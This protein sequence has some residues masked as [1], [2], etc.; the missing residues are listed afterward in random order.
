[1]VPI[2]KRTLQS[3]LALSMTWFFSLECTVNPWSLIPVYSIATFVPVVKLKMLGD[4]HWESGA[5]FVLE[6]AIMSILSSQIS[7]KQIALECLEEMGVEDDHMNILCMGGRTVGP[8]V[9]WDLVE[10][11]L[12][13]SYSQEPRHLR[14]LGKVALLDSREA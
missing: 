12:N 3:T 10:T 9:A 1:M 14:R 13:A 11:F 2:G 8:L 4:V 5:L 6:V 7:A